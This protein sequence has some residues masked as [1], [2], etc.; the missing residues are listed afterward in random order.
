[1]RHSDCFLQNL[2]GC[3][4]DSPDPRHARQ[5]AK[6]PFVNRGILHVLVHR[7]ELELLRSEAHAEKRGAFYE[8]WILLDGSGN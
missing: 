7:T 4:L 8:V 2:V 3:S 6:C 5:P 1:M